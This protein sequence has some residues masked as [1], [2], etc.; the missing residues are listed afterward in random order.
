[1]NTVTVNATATKN[2][3]LSKIEAMD[4]KLLS[5]N[6]MEE[7]IKNQINE[8]NNNRAELLKKINELPNF[9]NVSDLEEA[10]QIIRTIRNINE[11]SRNV[12]EIVQ[13]NNTKPVFIKGNQGRKLVRRVTSEAIELLKSNQFTTKQISE[14]MG[15][16]ASAI[17][18]LKKNAGLV[19]QHQ[20]R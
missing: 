15:I 20:V 18:T 12:T 19:K 2:A 6:T 10:F 13:G 3:Q 8:I 14:R 16:S 9:L 7:S 11:H 17:N 4:E 5:L 1:M